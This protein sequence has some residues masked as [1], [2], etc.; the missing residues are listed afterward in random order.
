[1]G[2]HQYGADS[3]LRFQLRN[4]F[5]VIKED[6]R[7]ILWEGVES[8][9]IQELREACQT[10]GMRATGLPSSRYSKQLHEWLDLSIQKSIPISLLIMSRAFS[11][12]SSAAQAEDVLRSSISSLDSDTINEVVLS[13]ATPA[14]ENKMDIRKRKLESLQFQQEMIEEER[15]ETAEAAIKVLAEDK[16]KKDSKLAQQDT[17]ST[18]GTSAGA[19]PSDAK[20][21]EK[22]T[23]QEVEAI[24]DLTRQSAVSSLIIIITLLTNSL[25]CVCVC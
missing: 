14:D 18:L 3:F 15:G 20:R 17:K 23:V 8:L 16:A 21:L 10:R 2:L 4:K 22:L 1:M 12:T 24:G 19:P 6:D 5:R 7:R 11:I 25:L 13:L 9:T